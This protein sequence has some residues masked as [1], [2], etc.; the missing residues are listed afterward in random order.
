[1]ALWV[2]PINLPLG[3]VAIHW[4]PSKTMIHPSCRFFDVGHI[5]A[6]GGTWYTKTLQQ[7][8]PGDRIW[9]NSP[10]HGYVG[11][12]RV[13]GRAESVAT[14]KV[15]TPEGQVPVLQVAKRT[16]HSAERLNDPELCE[17]H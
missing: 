11:V 9:V 16:H 15:S 3:C 6:G 12:G 4:N 7:L 5:S 2:T 1:M 17:R 10:G 14:F 13:T 8:K